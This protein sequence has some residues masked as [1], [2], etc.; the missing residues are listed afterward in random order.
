MIRVNSIKN[1]V[2]VAPFYLVGAPPPP[3]SLPGIWRY[4]STKRT[5]DFGHRHG[6]TFPH[7][8]AEHEPLCYTDIKSLMGWRK[9]T[10]REE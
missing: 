9:E 1:M 10:E 4:P 8:R 2:P 6:R 3:P 5:E 7:G